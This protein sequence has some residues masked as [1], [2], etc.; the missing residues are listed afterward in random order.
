[1]KKKAFHFCH[2]LGNHFN[3]NEFGY[4]DNI[5]TSMR[6]RTKGSLAILFNYIDQMKQLGVYDN[7]TIILMAD[8]GAPGEQVNSQ[9]NPTFLIKPKGYSGKFTISEA[10][11]SYEDLVP[12]ILSL[13][14]EDSS[15]YGRTIF[16][17][18]EDEQRKREIWGYFYNNAI[19][20]SCA[21][22]YTGTAHAADWKEWTLEGTSP[23][24]LHEPP[25]ENVKAVAEHTE[26][27]EN[28]EKY[29]NILARTVNEVRCDFARAPVGDVQVNMTLYSPTDD[30][31]HL[32]VTANGTE[33]FNDA[34]VSGDR[35]FSIPDELVDDSVTLR[36][37]FPEAT[38]RSNY[39]IVYDF[40]GTEVGE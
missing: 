21:L 39:L 15:R 29:N 26:M 18:G 34:S 14:G 12:T 7:S 27:I 8:H 38:D 31:A 5:N 37:T 13:I 24:G 20:V 22:K 1:M 33:V 6:Q 23:W 2:F 36:F 11:I 10:P 19:G 9:F 16:E 25:N 28:V 30:P 32:V 35:S 3:L 17:I 4:S 40:S